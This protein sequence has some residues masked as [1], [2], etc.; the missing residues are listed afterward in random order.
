MSKI[1]FLVFVSVASSLSA[2]AISVFNLSY[3]LQSVPLALIGVSYSVAAFPSLVEFY[4]KKN[5]DRFME[6]VMIPIRQIIFWSMPIVTLFIVLRAQ[7]VRVILGSGNF[8][9]SDT[10]L[11][12]AALALFVISVVAQSIILL[13]IR[14]YYA[15][16]QTWKPLWIT[17][18]TSAISIVFAFLFKY[19]FLTIPEVQIFFESLFRITGVPGSSVTMLALA[20]SLGTFLNYWLLWF[21]FKKDFNYQPIF[22]I[23]KTT[24]QS[25][26][27]SL[28][29]GIVSY[30]SLQWLDAIF[31]Q[32]KVIEV[33][34]HGFFAGLLG[35]VVGTVYLYLIGNNE[36]RM[37]IL[38]A[39]S[40]MRTG[41]TI[42]SEGS[43]D[44]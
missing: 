7:I 36:I 8:D 40:K 44:L 25:I 18:S 32:T 31:S 1:V 39:K 13:L 5:L 4:N 35:L 10:R 23:A 11:T 38:F 21:S 29:I 37:L 24:W 34:A 9:W 42:I 33:F 6:H 41:Q 12:A 19:L 43:T 3:N 16:G 27:A 17:L 14:A 26:S 28:L 30:V 22:G 15:A 2:G 20:F